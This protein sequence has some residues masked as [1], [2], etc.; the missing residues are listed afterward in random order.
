MTDANPYAGL[1]LATAVR[2]L[3]EHHYEPDTRHISRADYDLLLR[4]AAAL[5]VGPGEPHAN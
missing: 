2:K 4:A 3:A 1:D 5:A